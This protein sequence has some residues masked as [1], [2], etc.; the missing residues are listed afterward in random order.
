MTGTLAWRWDSD[1][2]GTAAPNQNPGG[3]GI[4]AYNLRFPGQYYMAETGLNQNWNRDYDPLVGKYIESDP[5]GLI[6]GLGTYT[7]VGGDPLSFLDP[8]GLDAIDINYDSYPVNTGL[9]FNLPLGHGAVVA[10]DPLTGATRYYEF[11]RYSD[12]KCGN[13]VRRPIPDLKMGPNGLPDQKSLED[14]YAFLS[15][16]YG[17]GVH[18]S[19][20]YYRDTTYSAAVKYAE[21]FSRKHACY[22]LIGNNCK[23]FAYD[24]ATAH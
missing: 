14:L 8:H 3:L 5:L 18:V 4:F 9:G 2:F 24:A 7:Y 6:A 13:V 12:K 1:P 11:G 17:H 21:D 20:T 15:E 23:T 22:S 16:N 19:A 10:V